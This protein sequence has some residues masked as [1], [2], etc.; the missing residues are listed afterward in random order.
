TLKL[1]QFVSLTYVWKSH[2]QLNH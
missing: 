2:F 1:R